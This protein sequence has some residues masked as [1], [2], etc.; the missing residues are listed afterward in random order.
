MISSFY[1]H[2]ITPACLKFLSASVIFCLGLAAKGF[3]ICLTVLRI[4]YGIVAKK[5]L[6]HLQQSEVTFNKITSVKERPVVGRYE[7]RW[8]KWT[9]TDEWISRTSSF[10]MVREESD[11]IKDRP[12]ATSW[13][14][15]CWSHGGML[16]VCMTTKLTW[17]C[18]GTQSSTFWRSRRS[19]HRGKGTYF[20]GDNQMCL[21]LCCCWNK[22]LHRHFLHTTGTNQMFQNFLHWQNVIKHHWP[23][24]YLAPSG[25]IRI[26]TERP[27]YNTAC[28]RSG[29][30][31]NILSQ[32]M[33]CVI[34]CRV[35][36]V[37]AGKCKIS[38]NGVVYYARF[39]VTGFI[40]TMSLKSHLSMVHVTNFLGASCTSVNFLN[41][42]EV[43]SLYLLYHQQWHHIPFRQVMGPFC[44]LL[45]LCKVI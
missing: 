38:Y 40:Q 35:A 16:M 6:H 15:P 3:I 18:G 14:E 2:Y 29:W 9:E 31:R 32:A 39:K 36:S 13:G 12:Q 27:R 26:I 33:V 8:S 44:G 34:R 4:I 43:Q 20:H 22:I 45:F 37:L 10:K 25:I 19:L 21:L 1:V 23:D 41:I 30:R 17:S 42:P 5:F 24:G 11:F 28:T 7:Q